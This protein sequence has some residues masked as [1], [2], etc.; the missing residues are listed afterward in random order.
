MS[1]ESESSMNADCTVLQFCSAASEGLE[2]KSLLKT[3]LLKI[4]AISVPL[5]LYR[6]SCP[7]WPRHEAL[8]Q[9]VIFNEDSI[10]AQ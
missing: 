6:V 8:K 2:M 7:Q 4:L 3:S 1:E 9:E 5:K 10:C